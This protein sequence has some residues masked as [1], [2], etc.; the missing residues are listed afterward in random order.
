MKLDLQPLAWCNHHISGFN[1]LKQ[2]LPLKNQI[3]HCKSRFIAVKQDLQAL[4]KFNPVN[5]ALTL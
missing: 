2:D 4:I 5:Q 3:Y 1:T